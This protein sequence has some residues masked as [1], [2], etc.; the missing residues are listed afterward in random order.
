LA[1]Y[2]IDYSIIETMIDPKK[3]LKG[4]T[5]LVTGGAGFIGSHLIDH[6]IKYGARVICF[7]NLSTG[8]LSHLKQH[9]KNPKFFF[10][11][12]DVNKMQDLKKAFAKW[13]VD[14]IFHYAAVVGVKRTIEEPLKVLEDIE[15]IKNILELSRKHKIKKLVY[16]SSSEIYGNQEKM[17]LQ[18]EKSY[19]DI[20][21]PYAL[22]KSAGE[23]FCRTYWET[24][25]LPVTMLRFFNVY[26]PRQE[27]SQYGFVIGVFISQVLNKEQPTIF[28]DGKQTRDFMFINDNIEGSIQALLNEKSNGEAINLGTGIETSILDLAKKIISISPY[29][30]LKPSLLHKRNM[31]EIKRRVADNKK[32]LNML[33]F[34][35]GFALLDGLKITFD[36]YSDN[37]AIIKSKEEAKFETYKKKVWVGKRS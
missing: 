15:G 27:S 23:N 25:G 32:M 10:I 14:Y 18:E 24:T 34:K 13:P 26:G 29:K 21:F 7:D 3:K 11:K 2:Y 35:A 16:A 28:Y 37:P 4:K 30:K 20:K 31:V 36:W 22:V 12:G 33:G 8:K 1:D 5:I 19:Y 6:L 17:P 9:E